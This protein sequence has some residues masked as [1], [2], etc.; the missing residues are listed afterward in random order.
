[1]LYAVT[2][3]TAFSHFTSHSNIVAVRQKNVKQEML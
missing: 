2:N 3:L 1:M